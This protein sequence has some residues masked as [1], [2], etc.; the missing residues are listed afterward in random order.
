[1]RN[2]ERM[3]RELF[4][5]FTV[6][7]NTQIRNAVFSKMSYL[8]IFPEDAHFASSTILSAQATACANRMAESFEVCSCQSN[9]PFCVD[10][11]KGNPAKLYCGLPQASHGITN[12]MKI[13]TFLFLIKVDTCIFLLIIPR[14][15]WPILENLI[16]HLVWKNGTVR[17]LGATTIDVMTSAHFKFMGINEWLEAHLCR[18]VANYHEPHSQNESLCPSFHMK[19]RFHSHINKLILKWVVVL[20]AS[21]CMIKVTWKW[22]IGLSKVNGGKWLRRPTDS[23]E[24]IR[25]ACSDL[26][27]KVLDPPH[28]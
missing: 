13:F 16:C 8:L 15:I 19:M 21:P 7:F 22:T 14:D 3:I 2:T 28:L 12:F 18:P 10:K 11:E 5:I 20:Q 24:V 17:G 6:Q 9:L 27:W 26:C 23:K 4:A 1:M 25:Q